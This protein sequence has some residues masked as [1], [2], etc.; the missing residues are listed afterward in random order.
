MPRQEFSREQK[1]KAREKRL[2]QGDVPKGR[3]LEV[4]HNVPAYLGGDNS[5]ENSTAMTRP[6]H[7]FKHF[8]GAY[9]PEP[10]QKP[11]SEH[12]GMRLVAAR[13]NM[14]EFAEFIE[15]TGPLT[16]DLRER[17]REREGKRGRSRRKR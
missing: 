14:D 8:L 7:G 11:E 10:E 2:K 16:R 15:M 6:E 12:K 5:D 3:A 13:M 4:D 9:Y 1:R 17:R